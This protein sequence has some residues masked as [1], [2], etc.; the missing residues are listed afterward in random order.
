MLKKVKGMFSYRDDVKV[1]LVMYA[2]LIAMILIYVV[3]SALTFSDII[4]SYP[5]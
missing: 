2:V 5:C 1:D 3:F 4:R